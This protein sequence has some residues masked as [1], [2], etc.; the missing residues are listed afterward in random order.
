MARK[1]KDS[2][3]EWIGQI[4]EDWEIVNIGRLFNVKAG[5]DAKPDLY[6]DIQDTEH[7][8][9]QEDCSET[10]QNDARVHPDS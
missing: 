9:P 3:V 1:M 7:P 10:K 2:G 5:G 8:F 6:S 4:P